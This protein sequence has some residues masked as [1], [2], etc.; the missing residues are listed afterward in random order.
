MVEV[1]L[2]R[3][4]WIGSYTHKSSSFLIIL[5]FGGFIYW[6]GDDEDGELHVQ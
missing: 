2:T 3:I 1:R 6:H 5:S 4:G